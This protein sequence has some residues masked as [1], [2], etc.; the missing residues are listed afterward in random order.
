MQ[1]LWIS[2]IDWDDELPENISDKAKKWFA[3][4]QDLSN[5]KIGRCL[6]RPTIQIVTDQSFHV[7]SDASED[8]YAAVM[9][10]RNV[11]EDGSVSISFITSGAT[12][13]TWHSPIR[14]ARC[15]IAIAFV[16][17]VAK[18]LGDHVMKKSVYWCGSM[19][20]LY[21]VKNPSIKFKPFV[22]NQIG[23][24]HTAAEPTQWNF[25]DER[26]NLADIGNRGMDIVALSGCST[27]WNGPEFLLDNKTAWPQQKFELAEKSNF[28]VQKYFQNM[29][30][31]SDASN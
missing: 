20:V 14:A 26:I 6:R 25:V 8:A 18:V 23:E 11:Y 24:I 30:G 27:W 1:E 31:F 2:R 22:A 17:S 29:Y 28:G 4:L 9:Y 15:D 19:N 7:L 21:Q 10:E 12:E 5:I 13:A 3:E 16:P